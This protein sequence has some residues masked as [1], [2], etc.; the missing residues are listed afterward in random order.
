MS[1]RV[2]VIG[3]GSWTVGSH[4]PNLLRHPDVELVAVAR[5]G[6]E[7][8]HRVKQQFGFRLASEDYREVLDAGVDVCV[9]ASPAGLH[10]EHAKAAL[11]AGAHVMCEKPV[12]VRPRD[13]WDLAETADRSGLALV[14]AFGWN[15]SP[16]VLRTKALLDR[17]GIGHLE[18][19]TVHMSS[20]TRELL[21]GTGA[22]PAAAPETVPESRTWTDP[23]LSGGGY[24]QAQLTHA[25]GLALWL[26]G[27]R[28]ES[29]FALM[30][31]PLNAPVELHDAIAYS[32][33]G[34][35]IGVVSGASTHVGAG[36][37]KHALEIRAI[38]GEGQFLLDLE[39]EAVW[40]FRDGTDRRLPVADG[41]GAY[42]CVGPID[43]VLAAARGDEHV[44]RS[45]GEL[46]ART[47][48]A[49]DIA[50]RSAVSGRL[51]HRAA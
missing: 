31:A 30:S 20:V 16:M 33:E 22:Y 39:R 46:G 43:A 34:G 32:Y 15:Y 11:E 40:F 19:L 4:L 42:D 45:P 37:N 29:G 10:H 5:K 23:A 6:P 7:L 12:T 50:Y 14:I 36:A 26:T 9:V 44:N 18:Q 8:L 25:L 24:G 38:G 35:A 41:E 28:A 51:E 3:A 49:L 48:E 2:G 47:V 27:A 1:I 17:E 21:S 13:A